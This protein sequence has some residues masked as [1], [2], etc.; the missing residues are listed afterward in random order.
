MPCYTPLKAFRTRDPDSLKFN[1]TFDDKNPDIIFPVQLPCGQCIGC[2]LEYARQWAVRCVHEAQLHEKNCFLTLTFN[3]ENLSPNLSL[4]KSDFQKFMKRLRKKYPRDSYGRISY[5]MC[6]E[7]GENFGRPHYHACIFGFD[8]PDKV[9]WKTTKDGQKLYTSEILQSLWQ[10]QGYCVIGDVTFESAAYVARYITKKIKGKSAD[11]YY[12]GRLPEYT[13]C[14][15]RPSIGLEWIQK[16][17]SDVYNYDELICRGKKMRPSRYYD[18]FYEK[19]FP[20]SYSEIKQSRE[21]SVHLQALSSESDLSRMN[22]KHELQLLR[23]KNISRSYELDSELPSLEAPQKKYD[24]QCVNY[25]AYI[26]SKEK[27]NEI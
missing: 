12:N 23:Q 6:G 8:F 13:A 24:Q 17:H 10:N 4:D 16:F 7:Y 21:D 14:S 11:D 2:R 1:I 5:Y 18:K 22:V 19:N 27:L 3:N 20:D 9:L 26:I 15:R 25:N